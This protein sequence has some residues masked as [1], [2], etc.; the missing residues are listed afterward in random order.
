MAQMEARVPEYLSDIA[1]QNIEKFSAIQTQFLDALNQA[2]RAWLDCLNK[3]VEVN[4]NLSRKMTM[5]KSLPEVTAA[6]QEWTTKQL[7]LLMAE[8]KMIFGHTQDFAKTYTEIV[9]GKIPS[10]V[11]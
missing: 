4:S 11:H 7:D 5:A 10:T 9:G 1:K 2:N 8:T 3:A 6:Y